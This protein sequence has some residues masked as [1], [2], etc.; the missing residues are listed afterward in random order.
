MWCFVL[1]TLY[2]LYTL[3]SFFLRLLFSS[4]FFF[5]LKKKSEN[6]FITFSCCWGN[7]ALLVMVFFRNDIFML[8]DIFIGI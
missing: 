6:I 3:G 1:P 7:Y 2:P 8:K 4:N 5:Y